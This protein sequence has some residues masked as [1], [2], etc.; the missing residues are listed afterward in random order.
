MSYIFKSEANVATQH[1]ILVYCSWVNVTTQHNIYFST[2]RIQP[3]TSALAP[4]PIPT[5]GTHG[6]SAGEGSIASRVK[7][8]RRAQ[9]AP[10]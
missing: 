7:A 5:V 4:V 1:D 10:H 9:S 2:T 8:R 3:L 6:Q